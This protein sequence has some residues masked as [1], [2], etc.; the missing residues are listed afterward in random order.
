M[1]S[2]MKRFIAQP[3]INTESACGLRSLI[4]TSKECIRA[5]QTLGLPVQHW[6]GILVF[7]MS[8][9]LDP[10]SRQF[11]ELSMLD[12]NVPILQDFLK[13]LESR[14]RAL[15]ASGE[16]QAT[17]SKRAGHTANKLS[18]ACKMCTGD[19]NHFQCPIL[20]A[21]PVMGRRNAIKKR[22][23]CFNCLWDGHTVSNCPSPNVCHSCNG[24]HHSLLHLEELDSLDPSL[25]ETEAEPFTHC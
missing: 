19:H 9:R 20:I 22:S 17:P 11:W 16:S 14:A 23:L 4:D 6:D 12:T 15:A 13:F 18:V 10:V 3:N 25:L 5:L 2:I 21:M 7:L 24:K 8:Q 1:F